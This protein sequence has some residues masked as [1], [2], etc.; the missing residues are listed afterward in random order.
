M[1][2]GILSAGQEAITYPTRGRGIPTVL[3]LTLAAFY[4]AVNLYQFIILPSQLLPVN[5]AWAWTLVPLA[6]L[7]NPFWSLLHESIHDLFYPQRGVNAFFG[8][9]LSVLFGAPFRILRMSHLLHHKLNRLPIEGTEYYDRA[10]S[11]KPRAA[12]GYYFQIFLGLYLVELLSPLFFFLPRRWLV[13]FTQR[14]IPAGGVSSFLMQNWL[15]AGS[16]R[17]I[18]FDGLLTYLW[19]ALAFL[20]YGEHWPLLAGLLLAR[21]FLISFLDNVYHYATPVG[22]I[23]YAKNLR[24]ARPFN[25]LLLN[26]NLHG[27]H[28]VNP[29]I[30]WIDLPNAFGAEGG[31]FHGG[32][33]A[34]AWRQLGGPIA[35]QDLPQGAPAV[36]LRSF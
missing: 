36:R 15:G 30:P 17:E 14:F 16:L 32:Y 22:N 6:L 18:R 11:T 33:F 2:V 35:L 29:A 24:L 28:H 3:N 9:L 19:L 8:R 7:T 27:V 5:L 21:G 4:L 13:W 34:A 31:K 12:P 26:F 20:C 10:K 23:F 25:N 1:G